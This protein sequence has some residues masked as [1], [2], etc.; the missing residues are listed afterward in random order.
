MARQ[1]K[2]NWGE[3]R[4][5]EA[6]TQSERLISP[7]CEVSAFCG[8]CAWQQVDQPLQLEFKQRAVREAFNVVGFDALEIPLPLTVGPNLNYRNHMEFTFSARRWLTPDEVKS[9]KQIPRGFALGLHA[10]GGFNRVLDV[11]HCHLQGDTA[12]EALRS[13]RVFAEASGRAAYDKISHNG[14]WRNLII[15]TGTATGDLSVYLITTSRDEELMGSLYAHLMEEGIRLTS[16]V[17]GVTDSV[18][19]TSEGAVFHVDHGNTHL[20]EQVDG[21]SFEIAPGAFFQPNTHTAGLIFKNV[22]RMAQLSDSQSAIDLFSG[23][24][25]LSLAIARDAKR[26]HGVEF[27]Q[28]AVLAA[29]RNAVRNNISNVTFGVGDLNAG[30]PAMPHDFDVIVADPPR[31]GMSEKLVRQLRECDATRIVS[32]GCNPKTQA[33]DIFRL[34]HKGP[35]RIEE[36]QPI[37]QFPQTPHVENLVSL[38]RD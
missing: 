21:L 11:A 2:K 17:N 31:A 19:D 20:T 23:A 8:G 5:E 24:G 26:V 10:P 38:V 29:R 4:L 28:P 22:C 9:D 27:V 13:V 35:F 12:N 36:I 34:V 14:F 6:K 16:L 3:L 33:R 18:A 30:L 32:V 15:R 7:P 25:T 37:D 1:R